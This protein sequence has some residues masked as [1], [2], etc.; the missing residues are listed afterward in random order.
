MLRASCVGTGKSVHNAAM[1]IDTNVDRN[2]C[3]LGTNSCQL[4]RWYVFLFTMTRA[5]VFVWRTRMTYQFKKVWN[6]A[7]RA[8]WRTNILAILLHVFFISRLSDILKS[9]NFH[10]NFYFY[11]LDS[12]ILFG[13][14]GPLKRPIF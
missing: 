8:T 7:R 14:F 10:Q 2:S 4:D 1:I 3:Q 9:W 13:I 11:I 6:Y 5:C 12:I